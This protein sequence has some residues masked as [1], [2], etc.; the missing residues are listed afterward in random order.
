VTV[1]AKSEADACL[2]LKQQLADLLPAKSQLDWQ[3]Q[4]H[5]DEIDR[6]TKLIN[7]TTVS[8]EQAETTI[9][10][11]TTQSKADRQNM[12]KLQRQLMETELMLR[13]KEGELTHL[14]HQTDGEL[15]VITAAKVTSDEEIVK[16]Q[17]KYQKAIDNAASLQRDRLE[18]ESLTRKQND[19]IER[20][21]TM[22]QDAAALKAATESSNHEVTGRPHYF[23]YNLITSHLLTHLLIFSHH[24]FV[25]HLHSTTMVLH[26]SATAKATLIEHQQQSRIRHE[27]LEQQ[28]V[29]LTNQVTKDKDSLESS[30][31][32]LLERDLL[33]R[34]EKGES[35]RVQL[36]LDEVLISESH[37]CS[38]TLL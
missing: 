19:E 33:I 38:L 29:E 16:W 28:I 8:R 14:K 25:T 37:C 21:Q 1:Q 36:L 12:E 15:T 5:H 6:L 18:H 34:Q 3:T 17:E 24:I 26:L 4:K 13:T 2:H 7:A 11:L 32:E 27:L 10:E 31:K 20:L 30:R 9:I 23:V 22:L 35:N